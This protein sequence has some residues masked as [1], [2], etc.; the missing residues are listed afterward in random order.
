MKS[1][2]KIVMWL[3][4][5]K[6]IWDTQDSWTEESREFFVATV[7]ERENLNKCRT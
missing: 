3:Q 5:S 1:G 6:L 4:G 7:L 2:I